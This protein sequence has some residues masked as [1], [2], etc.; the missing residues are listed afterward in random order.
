M[1]LFTYEKFILAVMD[2]VE[3]I[4]II[5]CWRQSRKISEALVIMHVNKVLCW[6][7]V[8]LLQTQMALGYVLDVEL[9]GIDYGLEMQED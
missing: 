6:D 4:Q 8:A 9:T 7:G 2:T 3:W 1:I 5:Q